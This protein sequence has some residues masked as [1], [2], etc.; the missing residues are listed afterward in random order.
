MKSESMT[1]FLFLIAAAYDAILGLAFLFAP[2]KVFAR[3]ELEPPNHMGYIQFPAALLLVF[4][5]MFI[6]IARKPV[7]NHNLIPFG[8]LLKVSYC[9]VVLL[10]WLSAGVP[11]IWKPF[12]VAD[13]VFIALF[14]LAWKS[15]A[16]VALAPA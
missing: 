5:A 8:I 13:L 11:F 6:V 1:R 14:S 16:K 3:L 12:F 9:G 4:A 10:H 2:T 7:Q 15:L